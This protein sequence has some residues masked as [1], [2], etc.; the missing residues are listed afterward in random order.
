VRSGSAWNIASNLFFCKKYI[1]IY[2]PCIFLF[3]LTTVDDTGL[4]LD[5]SATTSYPARLSRRARRSLASVEAVRIAHE[6]P[7]LNSRHVG[8]IELVLS[9]LA[10]GECELDVLSL[11]Q[12]LILGRLA[13]EGGEVRE[14]ILV[15]MRTIANS[16]KPKSRLVVEPLDTTCN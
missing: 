9:G 13:V 15:L 3:D 4:A 1:V 5:V 16:N 6:E 12:V 10:L 7:T 8:G 14:N 11:N 2:Y